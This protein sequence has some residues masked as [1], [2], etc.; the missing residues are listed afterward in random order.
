MKA[1]LSPDR[2]RRS[3][4]ETNLKLKTTADLES[5]MKI[6]GQPRGVQAIEFGDAADR[7]DEI[8]D[9]AGVSQ[10]GEYG[11]ARD[12]VAGRDFGHLRFAMECDNRSHA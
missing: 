4:D 2:L 8:V 1:P 7:L 12:Q 10:P 5:G 6:I 11:L 3:Y 9:H